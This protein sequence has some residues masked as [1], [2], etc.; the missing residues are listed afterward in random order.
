[1]RMSPFGGM[2]CGKEQ[3]AFVFKSPKLLSLALLSKVTN[4]S[5]ILQLDFK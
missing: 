4:P 2:G 5:V 3:V 1:M